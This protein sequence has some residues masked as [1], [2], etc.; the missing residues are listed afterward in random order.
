MITIPLEIG[1]VIL[2]GRFKNKKITV[3]EIGSDEFGLPTVNGRGIMKIRIQKMMPKKESLLRKLIREEIENL[4]ERDITD[5]KIE[6]AIEDLAKLQEQL[7]AGLAQMEALK[8][9]LNISGLEKQVGGVMNDIWGLF[10]EMKKDGDRLARTKNVIMTIQR[11]VAERETFSYEKALDFAMTQVNQDVQFKI[12]N[13]L[14]ITQKFTRVK[15]GLAFSKTESIIRESKIGDFFLK[16]GN[17]L[18]S[19][20]PKFQSQGKKIDANLNKLEQ[21]IA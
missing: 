10:E 16:I 8:K 7:S 15:P 14:K 6:K 2:A 13:E 3:K 1:D 11:D 9:Q 21:M 19:L 18:K 5:P 12:L 20:L 17:Y 4:H